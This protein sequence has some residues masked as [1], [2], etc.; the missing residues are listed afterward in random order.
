MLLTST[1]S[2]NSS[3]IQVSK[4]KRTAKVL[5]RLQV[6]GRGR[7]PPRKPRLLPLPSAVSVQHKRA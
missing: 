5:P 2:V 6:L 4:M 3:L 1:W 7:A